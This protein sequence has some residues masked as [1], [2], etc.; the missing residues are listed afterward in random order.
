MRI[1]DVGRQRRLVSPVPI[2]STPPLRLP[3]VAD[4]LLQNSDVGTI[5]FHYPARGLPIFWEVRNKGLIM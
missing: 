3:V 1:A 4:G 5:G 2:I